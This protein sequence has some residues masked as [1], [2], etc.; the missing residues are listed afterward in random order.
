M[1]EALGGP[2]IAAILYLMPM[3]AVYKVPALKAY[4]GRLS[5]IFVIVAGLMSM[6]AIFYSFFQ[7]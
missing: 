3:Y 4:R 6:T 5:N 1:I 2:V 7:G